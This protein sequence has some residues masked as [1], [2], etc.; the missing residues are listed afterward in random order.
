MK[1][2]EWLGTSITVAILA[3]F[4]SVILVM[5]MG[6]SRVFFSMANDG[7][8][9][10]AFS[11]LHPKY[12]TPFKANWILFVF[13]G[14]FAGFAPGSL[15]GDLTSFGTLF[16]FVIVCAGVLTLA[17]A[18]PEQRFKL[19]YI[20]GR[21]ILPV[22]FEFLYQGLAMSYFLK[23]LSR[24]N[25]LLMLFIFVLLFILEFIVT[26]QFFA[27]N[28]VATKLSVS[29]VLFFVFYGKFILIQSRLNSSQKS[30]LPS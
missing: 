26:I 19:P 22:L 16:A 21:V 1:G 28:F 11:E 12:Q 23:K 25:W 24:Q 4:S 27:I 2:Y 30:Q 7:L 17:P 13:V 9:P 6:Q 8:I 10:K 14:L 29:V 18:L 20:N 3:G 5:L 15:A